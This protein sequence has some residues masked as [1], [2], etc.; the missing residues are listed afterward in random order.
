MPHN[1]SNVNKAAKAPSRRLNSV[2]QQQMHSAKQ[3]TFSK[4]LLSQLPL[5][6][7]P[8]HAPNNRK[9]VEDCSEHTNVRKNMDEARS[10]AADNWGT[11][12]PRPCTW[13][14][15][16]LYLRHATDNL[17]HSSSYSPESSQ[18]QT[19]RTIPKRQILDELQ[20][21]TQVCC[22][23]RISTSTTPSL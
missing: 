18:A 21:K 17:C 23:Q 1:F 7:F 13:S 19:Q 8:P 14:N 15:S 9:P 4:S 2:L 5:T 10:P 16:L 22:Q 3:I 11:D 12:V 20:T 6:R